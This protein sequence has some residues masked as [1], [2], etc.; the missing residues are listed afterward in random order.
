M[1]IQIDRETAK[2]IKELSL[3]EWETYD[4]IIKRLLKGFKK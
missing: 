4:E 1:L 3:G 2:R